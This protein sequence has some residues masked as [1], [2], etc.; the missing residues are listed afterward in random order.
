[1]ARGI[2]KNIIKSKREALDKLRE[3]GAENIKGVSGEREAWNPVT[4]ET[5]KYHTIYYNVRA[6]IEISVPVMQW[7]IDKGVFVLE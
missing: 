1:M 3:I 6:E 7:F 4:G 2:R 5:T